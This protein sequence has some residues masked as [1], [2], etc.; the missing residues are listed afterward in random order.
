MKVEFWSDIICPWCGLTEH[1]LDVALER[2]AHRDQVEVVHRSFPLHPELPREGITQRELSR[3]HG[4]GPAATERAL[5]PIEE[6]AERE[7][8]RRTPHSSGRWG[9]LIVCTSC[10]RS[11]RRGACTLLPG[12]PRSGPTSLRVATCGW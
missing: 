1:R 5:R 4:M 2:F 10:S 9:R 11:P 12:G 6:L 8:L 3:R 7:G